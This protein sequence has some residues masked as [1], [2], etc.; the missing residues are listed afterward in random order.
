MPASRSVRT[1]LR[2]QRRALTAVQRF[3]AAQAVRAAIITQMSWIRARRL[4]FYMASDGELD[5]DPL[6]TLAAAEGKT[7][8]LPVMSD[9]LL[10]WRSAPLV[11]QRHDPL[12][13]SLVVNRFGILEPPYCPTRISRPEMLDFVFL[14]LVGF[15]RHG[16]RLG[17]GKGFYDRT[18]ANLDRRFRRPKLVGLAY[19]LQEVER[20]DRNPWDVGLDAIVTE[21]GWI[22]RQRL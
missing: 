19:S 8:Y 20:I 9:R 2:R 12:T 11:F 15:D 16:N 13:E 6:M 4:A 22:A 18:L 17:M 5:P 3:A 1:R 10:S 21:A 7:C 14:P